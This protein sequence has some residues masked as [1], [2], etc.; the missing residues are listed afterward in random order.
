[1]IT[2]LCFELEGSRLP[3]SAVVDRWHEDRR[4]GGLRHAKRIGDLNVL[5]VSGLGSNLFN[6]AHA[7]L[8]GAHAHPK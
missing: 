7:V 6:L 5:T 1:M 8:N 3:L 4:Q 2:V